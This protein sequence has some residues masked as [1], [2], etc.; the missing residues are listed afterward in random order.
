MDGYL[1]L[2]DAYEAVGDPEGAARVIEDAIT[3][4]GELE[5][6]LARRGQRRQGDEAGSMTLLMRQEYRYAQDPVTLAQESGVV[7]YSYDEYG[8]L[9][10]YEHPT[11][12]YDAY[13]N[14]TFLNSTDYAE[15]IYENGEMF[16]HRWWA[17]P[18]GRTQDHGTDSMGAAIPGSMVGVLSG[19]AGE[20]GLCMAPYPGED[21]AYW[22]CPSR[23]END[24]MNSDTDWAYADVTYDDRGCPVSYT[25]YDTSGQVTGTAELYWETVPVLET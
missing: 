23:V 24:W 21:D 15:F 25:S 11:Y 17:H 18:D 13:Q 1:G 2:A 3:Q 7:T 22:F 9:L 12:F 16:E 19:F 14:E 8:Y 10:S 5:E 20:R 6:L 4:L